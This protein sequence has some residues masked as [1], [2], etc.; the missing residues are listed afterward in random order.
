VDE[1]DVA[2]NTMIR[3]LLISVIMAAAC[4]GA[5]FDPFPGFRALYEQADFV[6]IV[7]LVKRGVPK[8]EKDASGDTIG[9]HRFFTIKSI[10][11]F[12]GDAIDGAVA[13]LADRRIRLDGGTVFSVPFEDILKPERKFL[14]FLSGQTKENEKGWVQLHGTRYQ[15]DEIHAEGAVLPVSPLTDLHLIDTKKPFKIFDQI[16]SDYTKYCEKL[17]KHALEQQ[18]IVK[19]KGQ[20]DAP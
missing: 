8:D 1:L 19:Q 17:H 9:P 15:W 4:K 13:R 7:T 18:R 2:N 6:G 16:V 12:K 11:V 20:Q 3:F 10:N 5:I 14:V